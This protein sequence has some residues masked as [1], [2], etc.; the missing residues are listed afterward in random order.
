M[1]LNNPRIASEAEILEVISDYSLPSTPAI[2]QTNPATGTFVAN[3]EKIND[4]NVA[5]PARADTIAQY[6]EVDLGGI[7]QI[8]QWRQYGESTLQ[9]G[10]G[11]W[12]I[13]YWNLKNQAW[14]DWVTGIV[15]RATADWS[16]LAAGPNVRTNGI[17]IVC[18]TVDTG[19]NK[20]QL[21]ELEVIR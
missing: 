10:D 2:F 15:T 16:T 1:T 5:L 18:V 7:Y 14:T 9:N 19:G 4:A 17:R 20:S 12:K 11:E 6:A 3:P 21:R 13:Q 8:K